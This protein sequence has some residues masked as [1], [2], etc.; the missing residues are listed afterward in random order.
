MVEAQER[1]AGGAERFTEVTWLRDGGRH[2]G[3]SRRALANT[4]TFD[5]ASVNVS[6]VHY[7]DEPAK[8]LASATALSTIIHPRHPHA[9]SVHIHTSWTE[10]RDGTG[11]WR[12]MTDLNPAIRDTELARAARERFVDALRAAAPAQLE[13]AARQGDRYFYIPALDRHRGVAHFYLEQYATSDRDAD[14]ALARAVAEAAIDTHAAIVADALRAAPPDDAAARAEQLAYHTLYLFQ[15]LTLD[16]GT[17]SGLLVHDQN[18]TGIL[19]SL[20]SHVDRALLASWRA[21]VPA[22]I[23]RLVDDLLAALP[24][25]GGEIDDAAKL[26]LAAAV[27][28]F[29]RTNPGALDL[30]ARGDVV[31]PTVANHR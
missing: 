27:R 11:Y 29:Y 6:Q 21:R 12:I 4:R 31:P 26:A 13:E 19:G 22:P 3:G 5:R 18:D 16:R 1:I 25:E 20:P 23:D 10:M 9:P 7:D 28:A 14:A 30:Q 2:G 17:T 15:V 8:R 24:P